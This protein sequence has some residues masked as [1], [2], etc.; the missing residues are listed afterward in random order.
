MH[1]FLTTTV[2]VLFTGLVAVSPAVAD[3]G[4]AEFV[5]TL[6]NEALGVIRADMPPAQKQAF[7]HQL[8]QQDFDVPGIARFVLGPS[9]RTASELEKQ[10]FSRLFMDHI[11]RVYS[12]RFAQYRGET[13]RVTGSRS[14]SEG[15]IVT[16]EIIRPQGAPPIKVDWRLSTRDG[17]YKISDVIIDGVSMRTSERSEFAS[18]IQR[19]GGQVQPLLAMLRE[20]DAAP[21]SPPPAALPPGV[22]STLPPR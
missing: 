22:G 6:G 13:L 19:S 12:E 15:A 18:V 9:W 2:F 7:F 4:P 8:L 14:D 17:L 21:T 10:E 16:S 5:R 20:K 3:T 1:R 11:V